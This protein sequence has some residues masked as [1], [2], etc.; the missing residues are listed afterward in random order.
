M[1]RENKNRLLD[2]YFHEGT[3]WKNKRTR[4]HVLKCLECKD[5]LKGLEET[6]VVLKKWNDEPPN[7]KTLELIIEMVPEKKVQVSP[8]KLELPLKPFV[9]IFGS[10]VF[11]IL[12]NLLIQTRI[13]LLPIWESIENIWLVQILGNFGVITLLFFAIASFITLSLTPVFLLRAERK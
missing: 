7:P 4:N 9:Q 12:F 13:T 10:V 6:D 5:Y 2:L 3:K 11:I 8:S 1:Y